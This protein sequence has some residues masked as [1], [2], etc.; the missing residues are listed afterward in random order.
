MW[1]VEPTEEE[2]AENLVPIVR[3]RRLAPITAID[4]GVSS[5]AIDSASARLPRLL[6]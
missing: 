3:G 4:D 6:R 5:P 2:I 1:A